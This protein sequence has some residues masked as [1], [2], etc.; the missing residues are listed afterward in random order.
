MRHLR[1]VV[2]FPHYYVVEFPHDYNVGVV[3]FLTTKEMTEEVL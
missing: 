2:E 3:T 1:G